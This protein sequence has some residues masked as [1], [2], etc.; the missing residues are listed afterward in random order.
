MAA[1][2]VAGAVALLADWWRHSFAGAT[3]PSP[4]MAK[5][6]LVNSAVDIG[7]ADRPN[8]HEGW[9]RIHLPGIV[10]AAVP[11]VL[12]DQ[13]ELFTATGQQLQLE[14]GVVD[15]SEPLRVSVAW[16]DAPG[17][18]GANPALVNNLD[19]TVETDGST[20][21]GNQ[22]AAGWSTTGGVADSLNNLENVFVANPGE[23]VTITLDATAIVGDGVPYNGFGVDQDFALVCYNCEGPSDFSDGFESGDTS[24][25]TSTTP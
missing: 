6:L 16:S 23:S 11:L 10:D 7:T 25:W 2:H 22:F 15:P 4:A 12:R 1:P 20:Y 13:Q 24:A 8:I 5:A 3:D 18:V 19:L 14:V 17:A 21:L 9:G